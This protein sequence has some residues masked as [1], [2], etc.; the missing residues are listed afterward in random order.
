[1]RNW[2]KRNWMWVLLPIGIILLVVDIVLRFTG[3][4]TYVLQGT[5]PSVLSDLALKD[6][7]IDNR[8]QD[9][10]TDAQVKL[11]QIEDE[12]SDTIEAFD[13]NQREEYERLKAEGGQ[14]VTEWLLR[15]GARR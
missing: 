4:K 9:A 11:E 15:V 1:M 5:N 12:Y 13:D 8:I 3:K 10:E 7:E 6:Q 14:A 2:L